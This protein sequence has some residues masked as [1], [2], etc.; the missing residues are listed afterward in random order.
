VPRRPAIRVPL[1]AVT[2]RGTFCALLVAAAL[3]GCGDD[4][5]RAAATET[6]TATPTPTPTPEPPPTP[7]S[8]TVRFTAAD[9][10][11]VTARYVPAGRNAPGVVLLHEIRGGPDQW[12]VLVPYLHAAGF[13][14]L[15]PSSRPS[16]LE[17]ER[18]P[19]ALAA[20][21]WLRG[22][23]EVDRDR[24]GLVGASIGASTTVFAMATGARKTV[25]AAV[26]LSPPDSADIW[27]LQDDGR[28]RPHDVLF[29]SDDREATS[30][31][32]MQ[33]GTVRSEAIRS[34]EAGH[35]VALLAE[36]DVRDAL[37]AWLDERV[38]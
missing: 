14:T 15:A 5:P 4:E 24:I 16:P 37:L 34:E 22:R 12:D 9:G 19:D 13:A 10:E 18:L 31:E 26:A 30:V 20:I 33:D 27:S 23:P 28:Y 6:A 7:R 36:A 38:R 2:R 3:A 35:G 29:I 8:R 25:D 1:R 21:R 32:G 11:R 17:A